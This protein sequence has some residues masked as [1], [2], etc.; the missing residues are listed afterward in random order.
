MSTKP[1]TRSPLSRWALAGLAGVVLLALG[2]ML[3][4]NSRITSAAL[5]EAAEFHAADMSLAAQDVAM[6]SIGQLVLLAQDFELGVV[7]RD[8]VESAAGEARRALTE[9]QSRT[10]ELSEQAA[11]VLGPALD[12]FQRVATEVIQLA[13]DGK[14]SAAA[15]TLVAQLVPLAEQIASEISTKRD[16]RSQAVADAQNMV[17]SLTQFAGFLIAFL[18]PLGAMLAYR[19]SLRRQLEAAAT[20]LD[21]RLDAERAAG[22]A[23][24]QFITKISHE[25]RTPLTSIYGFSELLLDQGFVDPEAAGDLVGLINSESAE[26]ARMVE[27]LLVAAHAEDAPLAIETTQVDIAAELDAVLAPLRRREIFVGGTHAPAMVLG[28]QLRIRQILRN[29]L[30]NAIQHGGSTI[31]IYGDVAGPNYVISVEDD[32]EGVPEP[33]EERLFS[34]YVDN[35]E[36]PLTAGSTGLG[37]AVAQ[38]LAKAMGGSLDYERVTGRTSFVLSLPLAGGT[39]EVTDPDA[40]LVPTTG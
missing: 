5:D 12:S 21:A 30:T 9:W 35:G 18:L 3:F 13:R 15:E 6:K 2:A 19:H 32:G 29:L 25:L 37:L 7:G 31:R 36:A 27:D 1:N 20:H 24:D 34:R 14:G 38:L 11:D 17:G 10:A 39:E 33:V 8:A 22:R 23:K 28:D 16:E 26:L 4:T 40:I